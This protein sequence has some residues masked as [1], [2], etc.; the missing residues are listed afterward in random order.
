MFMIDGSEV[1]KA[2]YPIDELFLDRWSPRALSGEAVSEE[3]LLT[4]FEAAKWAP[5]SYNNQ[6]WR[7]LYARR[8]TANW[9]LFFDLLGDYNKEWCKNASALI[10]FI[11]KTI[12][13]HNNKPASTHSFDAGAA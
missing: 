5:S 10:L 8:G 13:D 3:E 1:R 6:P 7:L 12:F 11:S 2:D 4:L 9:P